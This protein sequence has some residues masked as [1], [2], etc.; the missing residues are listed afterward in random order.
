[1]EQEIIEMKRRIE[2]L[3][4]ELSRLQEKVR[5]LEGMIVSGH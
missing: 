5:D 2:A 4:K 3:E 1:M